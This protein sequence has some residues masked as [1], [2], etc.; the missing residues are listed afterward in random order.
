MS[1]SGGWQVGAKPL[2]HTVLPFPKNKLLTENIR[3]ENLLTDST[4]K[5]ADLFKRGYSLEQIAMMRHL[6][7]STIEDHF[8]E[9]AMIIRDFPLHQFIDEADVEK[10]MDVLSTTESKRL[11]IIREQIPQFSYFQIR[12]VIAATLRLFNV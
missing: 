10:V 7:T 8:V 1:T 2:R 5:T 3:I 6:K 12:L 4:Q 11:K 9:M